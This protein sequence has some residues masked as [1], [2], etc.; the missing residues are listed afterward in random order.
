[1]TTQAIVKEMLA[2]WENVSPQ[3]THETGQLYAAGALRV[4]YVGLQCIGFNSE[5]YH[6]V[7]EQ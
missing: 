3:N 2:G 1:Q 5:V 6:A 4:S 7:L